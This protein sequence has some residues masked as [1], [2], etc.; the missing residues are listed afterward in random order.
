MNE[1][2][3]KKAYPE[4]NMGS[5]RSYLNSFSQAALAK[6]LA[7]GSLKLKLDGKDLDLKHKTHIYLSAKERE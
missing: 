4:V 1:A 7:S 5:L 3:V 6:E 2:E